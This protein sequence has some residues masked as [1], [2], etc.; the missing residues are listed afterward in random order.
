MK[1]EKNNETEEIGV[2]TP[3]PDESSFITTGSMKV[4]GWGPSH[5]QY[6]DWI[7]KLMTVII[8]IIWKKHLITIKLQLTHCSLVLPYGGRDQGHYWFR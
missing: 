6:L 1:N 2:V 4:P 3:T 7:W 5:Q 8:R